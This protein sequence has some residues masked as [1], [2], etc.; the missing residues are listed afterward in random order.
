MTFNPEYGGDTPPDLPQSGN[1]LFSNSLAIARKSQKN[2][3]S[4]SLSATDEFSGQSPLASSNERR[5][6]NSRSGTSALTYSGLG[7]SARTENVR[8]TPIME[9]TPG[10]AHTNPSSM[11]NTGSYT[12]TRRGYRR[13]PDPPA[14]YQPPRSDEWSIPTNLPGIDYT[15]AHSRRGPFSGLGHP[16]YEGEMAVNPPGMQYSH[17]PPPPP[18]GR[19]IRPGRSSGYER[20]VPPKKVSRSYQGPNRGR[21]EKSK[22]PKDRMTRQPRKPR[23]WLPRLQ[24][25]MTRFP[26]FLRMGMINLPQL[27]RRALSVS[28]IF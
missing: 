4:N 24:S 11:E 26:P 16:R 23:K 13:R 6:E 19:N 28:M 14:D 8:H 17:H 27:G 15:G 25:F 12:Y 5:P 20:P 21:I 10:S 3:T 18:R 22:N 9:M 7:S 2:S 1:P